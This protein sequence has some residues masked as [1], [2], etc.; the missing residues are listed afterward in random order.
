MSKHTNPNCQC[1]SCKSKRGETFGKNNGNYKGEAI[2]KS[3]F[4]S[5]G[6]EKSKVSKFCQECYLKNN[7]PFTGRHPDYKGDK[8]PNY[9]NHKL[10]GE[11]HFFFGKKRPE[12]TGEKH[13]FFGKHHT[14]ENKEKIRKAHLGKCFISKEGIERIKK[15]N[16]GKNCHLY[17]KSAN[18]GR[19]SYYKNYFM[20]STWEILFTKFLDINR[21]NW[22]YEPQSFDLV[23]MTYTPDFYLPE[24]NE[25]I[26]IKGWW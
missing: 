7:N 22:L 19:G 3:Y 4:C 23:N 25:Y 21:I 6:K 15:A 20:R 18:H 16:S 24:I 12:I 11:N 5:C 2:N 26:E 9:D 14:E 17:G 13:Y 10:A 1:A 8:N